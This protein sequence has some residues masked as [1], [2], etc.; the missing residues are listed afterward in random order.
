MFYEKLDL[1]ASR[2][3]HVEPHNQ[4]MMWHLMSLLTSLMMWQFGHQ[5]DDAN[6]SVNLWTLNLW[7]KYRS[8]HT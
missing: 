5:F 2:A 1:D 6:V 4:S 3:R 8:S 7:P